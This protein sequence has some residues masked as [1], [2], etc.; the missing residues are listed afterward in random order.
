MLKAVYLAVLSLASLH[1]HIG[2]NIHI[3]IYTISKC[4]RRIKRVKSICEKHFFLLLWCAM[5]ITSLN[6][7]VCVRAHNRNDD[8][9][10]ITE[11][12]LRYICT[13]RVSVCV[14]VIHTPVLFWL[15]YARGNGA[16]ARERNGYPSV[17]CSALLSSSSSSSSTS[18]LSAVCYR[19]RNSC[20]LTATVRCQRFTFIHPGTLTYFCCTY[21]HFSFLCWLFV[22]SLQAHSF[23][24]QST[25]L[26]RVLWELYY[27]LRVCVLVCVCKGAEISWHSTI[28]NV[29]GHVVFCFSLF[30]LFFLSDFNIHPSK[31]T[32]ETQKYKV[33]VPVCVCV[34]CVPGWLVSRFGLA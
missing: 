7:L 33:H 30:L 18:T 16:R 1:I 29:Y 23:F 19:C 24:V 26:L 17:C 3:Y 32:P 2:I 20:V 25:I 5:M 6:V 15:V 14:H 34:V 13:V 10:T 28:E 8:G 27:L 9:A 31:H 12:V 21:S 4:N 22:R 11:S